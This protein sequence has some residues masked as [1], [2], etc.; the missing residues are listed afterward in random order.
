MHELF[1]VA[2]L[3]VRRKLEDLELG[4][5]TGGLFR[6]IV[7]QLPRSAES[8]SW[9]CRETKWRDRLHWRGR[10]SCHESRSWGFLRGVPGPGYS[11]LSSL[12]MYSFKYSQRSRRKRG[13]VKVRTRQ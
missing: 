11:R 10:S 1:S 6:I 4:G 12:C 13:G 7:C 8:W 9:L 3:D 5:E 2:M